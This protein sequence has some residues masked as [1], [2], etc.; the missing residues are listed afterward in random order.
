VTSFADSSF[1]FLWSDGERTARVGPHHKRAIEQ[2]DRVC[3][4]ARS[5]AGTELAFGFRRRELWED[6]PPLLYHSADEVPGADCLL[7]LFP[8]H[9]LALW[10]G[11]N[12]TM[13]RTRLSQHLPTLSSALR[14]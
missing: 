9:R 8:E 3:V 11:C 14:S 2:T 4:L 10:V 6:G 1:L 12:T 5:C 7:C 13:V